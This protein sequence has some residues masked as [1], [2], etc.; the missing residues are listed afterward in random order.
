[1]RSRKRAADQC[2]L[3]GEAAVDGADA[4]AGRPGDLIEGG[5]EAAL[6]EDLRR[7]GEDAL[8]VPLGIAAEGALARLAA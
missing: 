6:G 3:V 2:L 5:V 1:M 4:D 7:G 8:P